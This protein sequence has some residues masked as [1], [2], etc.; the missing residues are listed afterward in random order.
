MYIIIRLLN[1]LTRSDSPTTKM[2]NLQ[3][4]GV[5]IMGY[6]LMKMMIETL[7]FTQILFKLNPNNKPDPNCIDSRQDLLFQFKEIELHIQILLVRLTEAMEVM[8][9]RATV[10]LWKTSHLQTGSRITKGTTILIKSKNKYTTS[11][12]NQ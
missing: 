2:L 7:N 6:S 4:L 5:M 9:T 10:L 11:P 8:M 3:S 12:F 1:K